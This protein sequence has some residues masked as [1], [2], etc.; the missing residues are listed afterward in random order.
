M[1]EISAEFCKEN[2]LSFE[3]ESF[4]TR[5]T[6]ITDATGR[7]FSRS[8]SVIGHF[9]HLLHVVLYLETFHRLFNSCM[10]VDEHISNIQSSSFLLSESLQK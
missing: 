8:V 2:S 5:V 7:L 9:S 3:G 6:F 1:N 4:F 10:I